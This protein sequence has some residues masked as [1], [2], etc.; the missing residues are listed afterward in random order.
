MSSNKPLV[1]WSLLMN[2]R[3]FLPFSIH[4]SVHSPNSV[5]LVFKAA[6]KRNFFDNGQEGIVVQE[7]T[8]GR[9]PDSF[10][11]SK[12]QTHGCTSTRLTGTLHTEHGSGG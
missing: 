2:S 3:N 6:A 5:M 9:A 7:F 12:R 4:I 10:D 8:S 1:H 11:R